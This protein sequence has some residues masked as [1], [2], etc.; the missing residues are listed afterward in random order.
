MRRKYG[1][2]F[3]LQVPPYADN[4]V[5]YSRPEHIK[6][7]F[8]AD[9]KILHAGEGNQILGFVMGEHS[10]LMTDEGAHARMRSLLMPAFNGAALRGYRAMIAAVA[11]EHIGQWP[12]GSEISALEHMNA[13][14]L[15]IIVRV[16]FG[17]TD[18]K[19]KAELTT[20]LHA[21]ISIHPVIFA[22]RQFPVLKRFPPWKGSLDNQHR[23]DAILYRE[24]AARRVA[25]DLPDR[26]GG[27]LHVL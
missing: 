1:N 21:I 15:D 14:T 20:R 2:V 7:I 22:G 11:A 10:V 6:E 3:S 8:A 17:V 12:A 4:P 27:L 9:P 26:R 24:I 5:V 13:L 19:T 18:P 25:L 16:V 23:I